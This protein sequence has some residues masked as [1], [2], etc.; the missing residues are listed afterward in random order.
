VK[1]FSDKPKLKLKVLRQDKNLG[2]GVGVI[3]A[4]DWFFGEVECGHILEDDLLVSSGFFQ[5]SRT[6]LTS[7]AQDSR[8]MMVSGTEITGQWRDQSA[9]LWSNY[10]MIWGWSTWRDRWIVMRA[11]LLTRKTSN[12]HNFPS[13]TNC[14]WSIGANRVL[15]GKVDTWDTPL[16]AEFMIRGWLSVIPPVNLVSNFG[17]D[18]NASHTQS[19]SLG[20]NLPI[21]D[22]PRGVKIL[23]SRNLDKIKSYNKYLERN[24]FL[25]RKKHLFLP[26]YSLLVD[27]FKYRN[28]NKPLIERLSSSSI[29]RLQTH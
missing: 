7:F 26:F 18:G 5:F 14:Y 28:R 20:L 2:V 1:L 4:I 21:M 9:I 25:I 17:D 19:G 11:G 24:I 10:P 8:V 29:V 6:C 16:A 13:P 12:V 15:D 22:L 23:D 27:R 3:S